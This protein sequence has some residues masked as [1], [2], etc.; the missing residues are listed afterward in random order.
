MTEAGRKQLREA[1]YRIH[2]EH[3]CQMEIQ[4]MSPARIRDACKCGAIE[5]VEAIV[6]ILRATEPRLTAAFASDKGP[7]Q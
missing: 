2:H 4:G 5:A 7:G 6:D 3:S 1:S